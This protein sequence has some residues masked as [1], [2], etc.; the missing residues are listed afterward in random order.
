L[1]QNALNNQQQL[2]G[3]MKANLKRMS[4]IIEIILDHLKKM[5]DD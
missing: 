3:I 5:K 1:A 2:N 4:N